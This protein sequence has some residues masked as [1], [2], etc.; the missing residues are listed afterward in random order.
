MVIIFGSA[1]IDLYMYHLEDGCPSHHM[2]AEKT[3]TTSSRVYI[4]GRPAPTP[5][6]PLL[7]YH[8]EATCTCLFQIYK[9]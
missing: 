1:F 2:V 3:P 6:R 7:H 9:S 8:W 5:R 4:S